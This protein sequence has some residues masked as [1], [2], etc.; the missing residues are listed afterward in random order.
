MPKLLLLR[1]KGCAQNMAQSLSDQK[2]GICLCSLN[3]SYSE[4]PRDLC[5]CLKMKAGSWK[6][7]QTHRSA[8]S[9]GKAPLLI[10]VSLK[11]T[12]ENSQTL[13]PPLHSLQIKVLPTPVT[14][15]RGFLHKAAFHAVACSVFQRALRAMMGRST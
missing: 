6:Q 1:Q 12:Q 14:P 9:Q 2:L 10:S 7:A 8:I 11:A 4:P 5:V 13:V 3:S 15:K